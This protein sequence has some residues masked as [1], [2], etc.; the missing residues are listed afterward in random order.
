MDQGDR[1]PVLDIARARELAA[2]SL[3]WLEASRQRIN[4]LNVYP[5]PDGDTG[6]NLTLTVRA[7]VDALAGSE[8]VG[9]D[10]IADVITDAALR[11]AAGNSGVIFSQVVRGFAEGLRGHEVVD[12]EV[13]ATAFRLASDS[14]Y[15]AV[16]TPVEGTMLTVIRE[17]AEEAELSETRAL[18]KQELLARVVAR[19]EDALAHTPELLPVLRQAG[20]VDAG[21]AGLLE[22][23]RGLA[24]GVAGKGAPAEPVSSDV[25]GAD[26][27]HQELSRFTYCTGFLVEGDELDADAL[28]AAL[29]PLGDS[30]LVVGSP[31]L[32]KVHVH[33]DDPGAALSVGIRHGTIDAVEVAD[34]HRQTR[35]REERLTHEQEPVA[36]QESAL[37]VVAPSGRAAALFESATGVVEGGQT[38][39]PSAGD[40]VDAIESMPARAVIVLPNNGNVILAAE[41][42]A[43]LVEDKDVRVV[44]TRSLQEGLRATHE[45]VASDDVEANVTRMIE[46]VASVATGE[47]TVA[48]R[49]AS[50]DGVDVVEGHWLGLLDGKVVTSAVELDVVIDRVVAG[51]LDDGQSILGVVV[52]EG[53]PSIDV[54]ERR[55]EAAA[56]TADVE[57]YDGGQPH[58]P[59]LLWS[60][61]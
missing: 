31:Q 1:I 48:S 53:A 7:I 52:G 40:I 15:R 19:G 34:M 4:D 9:P 18:P 26:A 37:V 30:L 57:I 55:L 54:L 23:V 29:E 51:L 8:D 11:G 44:P 47:V 39:N 49:G 16:P 58:Y 13:L 20:V 45:F 27:I 35:E 41:Q 60:E 38:M 24:A 42:A 6:T 36:E 17:M 12:G 14:A 3:A 10:G 61:P 2:S 33:T 25:L 43:T 56:S 21:G 32:L 59:L 22:I 50:I 5:V 46:G 28:R